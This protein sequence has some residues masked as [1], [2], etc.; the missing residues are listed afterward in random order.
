MGKRICV[1]RM[2]FLWYLHTPVEALLS[3]LNARGHDVTLV[4]SYQRDRS[5]PEELLPG[6]RNSMIALLARRLP[7]SR[8]L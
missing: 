4:K 5:R 7:K 1:L 6:I 8:F 2:G 3:G